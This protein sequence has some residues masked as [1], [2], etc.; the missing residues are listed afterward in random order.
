MQKQPRYPIG[1]HS[2]SSLIQGGCLYVDKT[3]YIEN[4]LNGSQYYFLGRP[5]RFGKSL[6][7]STLKCFFEGR[8]ELFKGLYADT[9]DWNWEPYPVFH[10]ALNMMYYNKPGML[11][12]LLNSFLRE[13]ENQYGMVK[14]ANDISMR[15]REIIKRAYE[16]TGK[17]VVILVDEYDN[18][19]VDNLDNKE[20]FEH[21]RGQLSAVYS[22]FKSSADYIR[23]VFL[24]GVSRFGKISV[25]SG[26]NNIRDISLDSEYTDI[27]GITDDEIDQY[28]NFGMRKL[29]AKQGI[30]IEDVRKELKHYYDGYHFSTSLIDIYNPFSFLLAMESAELNNYWIESGRTEFVSKQITKHKLDL[31]SF[32][33][34]RCTRETLTGIEPNSPNPLALL[35]QTG[36]LTIKNYNPRT[37]IYTLGLPNTEVKEGLINNLLPYYATMNAHEAAVMVDDILTELEN[38]DAKGFME[39]L[40]SLF[41]GYSYEMRLDNENNFHNVIYMLLLLLGINVETEHKTSDGRIDLLITTDKYRY[42]VELKVDSTPEEALRQIDDK[43]YPLQFAT[44]YRTLIKIG[45]NFSTETRR[46]TGYLIEKSS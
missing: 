11:E 26:L 12:P 14:V 23:L 22:N 4:I 6:F 20:L 42:V 27:C 40:K 37:K 28:F 17:Q 1:Q 43:E 45:A 29:S 9:M 2:F 10:I 46:I 8:R 32:F 36:Y 39:R 18:P 25:F 35:Y 3:K 34:S 24:T 13:W 7:L 5:R 21:Y 31:E 41:A 15:F 44:D 16:V 19:L 38:G 30:T 33:N